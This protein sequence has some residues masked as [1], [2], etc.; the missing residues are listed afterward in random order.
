M[1]SILRRGTQRKQE[2]R[3]M[4]VEILSHPSSPTPSYA[5]SLLP[6]F[7][8]VEIFGSRPFPLSFSNW[9][10]VF[11]TEVTEPR[12]IPLY[13]FMSIQ[14][15]TRKAFTPCQHVASFIVLALQLLLTDLRVTF[16]Q[17]PP[18]SNYTGRPIQISFCLGRQ[19]HAFVYTQACSCCA[20]QRAVQLP[21]V[22]KSSK[23]KV[24][25]KKQGGR[26]ANACKRKG[27]MPTGEI[28]RAH[29]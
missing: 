15:S 13:F 16:C 28:G 4:R 23:K 25:G 10:P 29:V 8:A 20:S 19:L 26:K 3:S 7:I 1:T 12:R 22:M 6:L 17:L 21:V 5:I 9:A 14:S 2:S 11:L 18:S 24:H 27:Q